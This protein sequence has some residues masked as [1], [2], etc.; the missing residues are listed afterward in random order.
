MTKW[1]NFAKSCHAVQRNLGAAHRQN[2]QSPS[3]D[4]REK[5]RIQFYTPQNDVNVTHPL[6]TYTSFTSK[7]SNRKE[8]IMNFKSYFSL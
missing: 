8:M 1:Q 3:D 2:F 6:V 5:F 4:S 7:V